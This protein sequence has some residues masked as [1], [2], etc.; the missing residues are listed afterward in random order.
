MQGDFVPNICRA[1]PVADMGVS[2]Q[3]DPARQLP[4][5]VIR[6]AL[7]LDRP[8]ASLRARAGHQH[9]SCKLRRPP[10]SR[11]LYRALFSL[12]RPEVV[13]VS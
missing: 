2:R 3:L 1:D 13:K 11:S 12:P 9:P 10:R 8:Q 6:Q 7:R 5:S 4:N